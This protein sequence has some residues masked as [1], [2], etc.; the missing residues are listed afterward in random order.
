MLTTAATLAHAWDH[1]LR[2]VFGYWQRTN[3]S[4]V[5]HT[6][7]NT[8]TR[9]FPRLATGPFAYFGPSTYVIH[10]H[11]RTPTN[12]PLR[13]VPGHDR[14]LDGLFSDERYFVRHR[15][16]LLDMFRLPPRRAQPLREKYAAVLDGTTVSLSVRRGEYAQPGQQVLRRLDLEPEWYHRALEQIPEVDRALV[17]SDDPE[18]CREHLRIDL[19]ATIVA[20]NRAVDDMILMSW[21]DHHVI[22]NSTFAWWGAWLDPDPSAVVVQPDRWVTDFGRGRLGDWNCGNPTGWV[23]L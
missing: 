12:R 6:G 14:M 16:R 15:A 13:H 1:D 10:E 3:I 11:D 18:W 4:A 2:P 20:G 23:Q 7:W 5:E 9:A 19:P 22:P 21:C 17:F 8:V